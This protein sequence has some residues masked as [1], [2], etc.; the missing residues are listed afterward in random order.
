MSAV[1]FIDR[2]GNKV[3]FAEVREGRGSF[4][5]PLPLLRALAANYRPADHYGADDVLSATTLI[6][7]P[8]IRQ[9]ERRH[10]TYVQPMDGIW[11]T[12]GTVMHGILE[13]YGIERDSIDHFASG[14]V[15]TEMKMT[16]DF[17]GQKI[18]GTADRFTVSSGLGEDWKVTSA[19]GI[20]QMLNDGVKAAKPEY[21]L[22]ANIYKYLLKKV[23]D[24]DAT[25]WNLILIARDYNARQHANF[26]PIEI[27]PVEMMPMD[28]IE[29]YI[30]QRI[31][32]HQAAALCDDDGLPNCTT[33]ETWEGRRCAK[34]CSVAQFCH[35]LHPELSLTSADLA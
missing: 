3:P 33:A 2:L 6:G 25:E 11:A 27:V 17:E 19:Y 21:W 26:R 24:L 4:D 10:D 8:Q 7:P 34:Y 9:L 18:A 14:D 15:L 16:Y 12:Y 23:H 35:Q 1:G 32:F 13:D 5:I 29:T 28:H 31:V 30:R 22:Q 20:K